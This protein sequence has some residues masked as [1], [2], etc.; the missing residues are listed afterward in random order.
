MA[1]KNALYLSS[2]F[3]LRLS[4]ESTHGVPIG[5]SSGIYKPDRVELLTRLMQEHGVPLPAAGNRT[6]GGNAAA[7]K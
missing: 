7:K 4:A 5:A 1:V 6:L 3:L 2:K